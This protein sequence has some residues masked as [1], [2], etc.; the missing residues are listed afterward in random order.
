MGQEPR[1]THGIR[2]WVRLE[3]E[4][5]PWWP[6]RQQTRTGWFSL[7][8][9]GSYP[10]AAA[11]ATYLFGILSAEPRRGGGAGRSGGFKPNLSHRRGSMPHRTA[12]RKAPPRL[13]RPPSITGASFSSLRLLFLHVR[14]V[15]AG[16]VLNSDS[17]TEPSLSRQ[18]LQKLARGRGA[19]ATTTPGSRF[20][21]IRTPEGVR[22]PSI[23]PRRPLPL[24]PPAGVEF[25]GD[26]PPRVFVA[27]APRPGANVSDPCRDQETPSFQTFVVIRCLNAC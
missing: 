27:D 23:L 20:Q 10:M 26:A 18:G 16:L 17:E 9:P 25:M 8:L 5:T 13:N 14:R 11:A 4:R 2:R 19:I 22:E 12:L 15:K 21:S 6:K 3:T 1:W 24:R 7:K